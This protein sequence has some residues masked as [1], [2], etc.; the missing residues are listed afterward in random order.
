[1]TF[2]NYEA[3]EP[4]GSPRIAGVARFKRIDLFN[5]PFVAVMTIIAVLA[6]LYYAFIAAPMY[7]STSSF[8]IQS[9][10]PPAAPTSLLSSLG[11][12]RGGVDMVPV[13]E[14]IQSHEMLSILDKQYNLRQAYSQFRPDLL[15]KLPANA[16]DAQ[17]LKFYRRMVTVRLDREAFIVEIDVRSFDRESAPKIAETILQR[18]EAFVDGMSRRVRDEAVRNAQTELSRAENEAQVAR[19]AISRFRGSTAAVDPA[20]AGAQAQSAE[21]ALNAQAATV[22]AQLASAMTYNRPDSPVVRQLRASLASIR[23]EA[24]RYKAQQAS[25]TAGALPGQVTSYETLALVRTAAEQKVAA[26]RAA[27]ETARALASQHEKFVVRVVNPNRPDVP[28]EPKRFLDFLM[29]ILF[30]MTGY[31]I[32]SL[33]IAGIRDHRGV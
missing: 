11:A 14:Y 6:G 2:Q 15:R 10:N 16:T 21:A 22:Q 13:Q 33:L 9:Q 29:V 4:G 30:A 12:A 1:M 28:T 32:V 26:T 20:A 17:F 23:A 27:Y 3:A 19:T 31:A 8:T 25:Q 7:V 18:S 24:A 5:V